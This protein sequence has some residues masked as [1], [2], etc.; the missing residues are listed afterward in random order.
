MNLPRLRYDPL[1]ALLQSGDDAVSFFARRDLLHEAVTSPEHLWALPIV[2]R[3]LRTQRPDG[4]WAPRG[5]TGAPASGATHPLAATYRQLR[6]LVQQY[7]MDRSH[8]AVARAAEYVFSCQS[9]EGDL[10]GLLGNQYAPYYT[11]AIL[12]LLIQAG[13]GEDVRV[14]RALRWLLAVR[15]DDGGWAPGSPCVLGWR[16][17]SWREWC[18][19]ISDPSAEPL[20]VFD[21]SRPFSAHA[22]GMALRAFAAH[23]TYRSSREAR[24]AARLLQSKLLLEDNW[25]SYRHPDHWVRFQFPFWWTNLV[26]ALDTISLLAV[27]SDDDGGQR[28]VDWLVEHQLESGLWDVSYSSIHRAPVRNDNTH[29]QQCWITLAICRVLQRLDAYT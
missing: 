22:T 1:P 8:P 28:A 24:Q 16:D 18:A 25:S 27:A 17:L 23:P 3:L 20:R 26:T 12:S 29:R 6:H 13:Y 15:Q 9:Q 10:R 14:E 4:S 21:G 5:K 11:G 7:E 19:I 2:K